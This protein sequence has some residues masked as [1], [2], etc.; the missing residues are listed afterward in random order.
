MMILAL[1]LDL[2]TAYLS[3]P[4]YINTATT[5]KY[6]DYKSLVASVRL[7][8]SAICLSVCESTLRAKV[9]ECGSLDTH[10]KPHHPNYSLV[11]QTHTHWPNIEYMVCLPYS[12]SPSLSFSLSLSVLS[13]A[14][15]QTYGNPLRQSPPK[16]CSALLPGCWMRAGRPRTVRRAS[17]WRLLYA[18]AMFSCI[19]I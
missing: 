1:G 15:N 4:A 18:Q 7:I 17:K 10:W 14:P 11:A 16:I 5:T 6:G 19:A 8:L 9:S 3:G 2:R 12:R 13:A